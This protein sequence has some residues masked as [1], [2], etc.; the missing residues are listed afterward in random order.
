[1]S[2][3]SRV[4]RIRSFVAFLMMAAGLFHSLYY[5]VGFA[6]GWEKDAWNILQISAGL[7]FALAGI[8]VYLWRRKSFS[9]KSLLLLRTAQIL[10]G[11]GLVCFLTVEGMIWNAG[12]SGTMEKS[13]YLLIL[14]AR[15]RGETV[16]LSLR[17]RL[18]RGLEYLE[19]FPDTKA[20]LSGGQGP[21]E[22]I[23]EAEAMKRYLVER[24]VAPE[25]IILE[26]RSTDTFQNLNYSKQVLEERGV[27]LNETSITLVTNDFHMFR[28]KLLAERVGFQASGLP[29]RTPEYTIPKA[30]TREFAALLKGYIFDR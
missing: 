2:A 26:D 25:R 29:A 30:Y 5:I 23:T 19:Q 13:D 8:W 24:G 1:M 16:S 10:V 12:R 7:I 27:N 18:E 4:V 9:G 28:A 3:S 15:V 22:S 20:V 21:G 17:D 11:A 14:G 6:R